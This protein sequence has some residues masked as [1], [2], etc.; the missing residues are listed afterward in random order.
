MQYKSTENVFK[1]TI[2]ICQILNIHKEMP[3]KNIAYSFIVCEN[4]NK[5]KLTQTY[6]TPAMFDRIPNELV[7]LIQN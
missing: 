2:Q 7:G 1:P 6:K 5:T 4:H 3:H